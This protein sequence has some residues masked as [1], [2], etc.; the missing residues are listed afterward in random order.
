MS[1]SSGR[2]TPCDLLILVLILI[3]PPLSHRTRKRKSKTRVPVPV[4]ARDANGKLY[5]GK[6]NIESAASLYLITPTCFSYAAP[7]S[8][9]V[10][11]TI[12]YPNIEYILPELTLPGLYSAP[13]AVWYQWTTST[14]KRLHI[15]DLLRHCLTN[16]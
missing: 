16:R 7:A 4:P 11:A 13:C 3:H 12:E 9:L 8:Y 1:A 5:Q 14:R 6:K 15:C 2:P 10:L